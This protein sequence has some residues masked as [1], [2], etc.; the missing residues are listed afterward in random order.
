MSF[1]IELRASVFRNG[2]TVLSL[3]RRPRQMFGGAGGEALL[4]ASPPRDPLRRCPPAR[5]H[6]SAALRVDDLSLIVCLFMPL[7]PG[8]PERRLREAVQRL[9]QTAHH[10][11]GVS[12]QSESPHQSSHLKELVLILIGF[13]NI[14]GSCCHRKV[15]LS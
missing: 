2:V 10:Q 13:Q 3:W 8:S 14:K 5:R 9:P 12:H 6:A 15:S 11:N 4:T 7:P 1:L